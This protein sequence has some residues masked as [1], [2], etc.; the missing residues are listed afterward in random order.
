[1][2]STSTTIFATAAKSVGANKTHLN[3]SNQYVG[4]IAGGVVGGVFILAFA[5][6]FAL[7]LCRRRRP[8]PLEEISCG[9]VNYDPGQTDDQVSEPS[10]V[11]LKY[12]D[13]QTKEAELPNARLGKDI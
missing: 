5:I 6:L 1:M 7:F 9:K 13:V 3:A 8:V 4:A 2:M 11:R 12:L 10:D